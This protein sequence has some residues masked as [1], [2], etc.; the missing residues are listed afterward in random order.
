MQFAWDW[1]NFPLISSEKDVFSQ[2]RI[3]I[4]RVRNR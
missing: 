4:L 1:F 3:R 2:A